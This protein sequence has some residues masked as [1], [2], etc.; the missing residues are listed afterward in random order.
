VRHIHILVE[1]QKGLCAYCERPMT[2]G[3]LRPTLD[4]VIPRRSGGRSELSNY[5]AACRWCNNRKGCMSLEEFLEYLPGF[6]RGVRGVVTTRRERR[7]LRE[8]YYARLVELTGTKPLQNRA[9]SIF[10]NGD[11]KAAPNLLTCD[12]HGIF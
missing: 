5:V 6:F 11:S 12:V 3:Q 8:R 2:K 10:L 7:V 1:R 4:H 9:N